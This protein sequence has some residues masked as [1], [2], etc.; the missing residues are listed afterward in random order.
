[1]YSGKGTLFDG[2]YCAPAKVDLNVL[3]SARQRDVKIRT[4][5]RSFWI[6]RA[7]VRALDESPQLTGF[8]GAL[9]EPRTAPRAD[10]ILSV[11]TH[12]NGKNFRAPS[13]TQSE[14]FAPK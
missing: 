1:M 11:F 6:C 8:L 7:L 9:C 2:F 10:Q 5:P 14:N 4:Q 13:P 3:H 12:A